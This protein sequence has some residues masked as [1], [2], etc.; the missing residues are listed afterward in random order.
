[1]RRRRGVSLGQMQ[2][3][4]A[5]V[6]SAALLVG[7]CNQP[8]FDF[9]PD[10]GAAD[11]AAAAT[12]PVPDGASGPGNEVAP[13]LS[14]IQDGAPA[15][16]ASPAAADGPSIVPPPPSAPAR[17]A[18]LPLDIAFD[19]GGTGGDPCAT[20]AQCASGICTDGVCCQTTCDVCESCAGPGGTCV[21]ITTGLDDDPP[22]T[23]VSPRACRGSQRCAAPAGEL[24]FADD[25]LVPAGERAA[26][27][28]V[29]HEGRVQNVDFIF[30]LNPRNKL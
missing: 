18:S 11:D 20:S 23:C 25:P 10:A 30:R 29:R 2:K 5:I 8:R 16:V 7:G 28:R 19:V 17:D 27:C 21:A 4:A 13:T 26:A 14:P 15:E 3:R 6:M 22:G 24:R 12:R 9:A 1:M